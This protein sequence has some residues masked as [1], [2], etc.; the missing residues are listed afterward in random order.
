MQVNAISSYNKG[1]TGVNDKIDEAIVQDDN[2]IRKYAYYQTLHNVKD[3]KHKKIANALWYSIPIAAGLSTAALTKGKVILF[4]KDIGG[5]AAKL[6]AGL[7]AGAL[8]WALTLGTADAVV[9][10]NNL[11]LKK[12]EKVRELE[13][14][15]SILT[16]MGVIAAGT[17][18]LIG[19]PKLAN[20]LL[21]K[22][23]P[24]TF[25]RFGNGAEKFAKLINKPK[26]PKFIQ[27]PI[28][29]ISKN[30][31]SLIKDGAE[32]LLSAAPTALLFT[33][34]FHSLNHNIDKNREFNKNYSMLKE[35]QLNLAKARMNE[36][37][38]EN[39]FLKQSPENKE[40]IEILNDNLKDMPEEVIEKIEQKRAERANEEI[41]EKVDEIAEESKD[42]P[43]AEV[44]EEKEA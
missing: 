6:A 32:L 37:K 42:S 21:N 13:S 10:A 38:M 8:P 34:F 43:K 41:Q 1:F 29:S 9:G 4:G 30:A 15:H 31:P 11:A 26:T 23:G 22:I 7:F 27:K 44:E 25:A 19:V 5:R 3:K 20:K 14:K 40:N 39:D 18:A 16:F 35:T 36:L 2:V 28:Q 33:A 17:A 24:K 12:S